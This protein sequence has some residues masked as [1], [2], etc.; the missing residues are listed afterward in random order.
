MSQVT[1]SRPKVVIIGAGFG[2]LAAA[3]ALKNA[4]VDIQIIDRR[5]Y[6]LF[7]PLLYQVATADLSPADVAW[8]IRGIFSGQKNVSVALT[9][10]RDVDTNAQHVITGEGTFAYDHLIVASGAHHSYF[11]RDDWEQHAPGLK[12]I[13]DATEIRKQVLMAFERAEISNSE[14]EQQRQLT[15]VVVG[16]G[17]TG[18]EMAGAIAELA[19][20]ALAADFHRI[21]SRDARVILIEASDRLL[22]AFPENL[23]AKAQTSLEKL[24]VDVRL[25]TMVEDI[26]DQGVQ[27]P[28][29]FI[30][31]ACKVWG[32][33]VAVKDVGRWLDAATDR[34]GRVPVNP[35]LSV[36]DAPNI[37]VIGDAAQ[38]PWKDGLDV[39]GIAPAAKQ[40]GKY[41]GQRIA[42]LVAGKP[43]D[44]PF[45]YKH[46]GNLATIGRHAAVIDFGRI[47]L[48]GF[49][50]WWLWGVA[51]IYFLI[52]V[53]N[54]V[55]VALNWFWSYLTFSKGARLI[56]GLS[57]TRTGHGSR[58]KPTAQAAE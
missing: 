50:A 34:T 33:G 49:V 12:R 58:P 2:G 9:E 42:A 44:T 26:T 18:V 30:P 52:G 21:N 56:T 40:G 32:A 39:P 25:N 15:F 46:A 47:Q 22:R 31:S 53:R 11:G 55:F 24:G 14:A 20:H 4:P 37:Y 5:N 29:Q 3:R 16:G 23:S 43:H 27:L 19:N 28:D 48:S 57:P 7:Q 13:I 1:P 8:P 45:R 51:H 41:V 17:P 36:P 35:D 38:V 6:H 54:P 10:V